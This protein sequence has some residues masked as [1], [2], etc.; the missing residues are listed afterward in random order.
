MSPQPDSAPPGRAASSHRDT[1]SAALPAREHGPRSARLGDFTLDARVLPITAL[2]LVV[3]AAGAGA[4]YCLLRL[5]GLITNL[6]FYQRVST[7]LVA[8]GA[9]HHNPALILLAPGG[10]RAGRSG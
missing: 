9:V 2:A 10:G 1:A 4:A 7:A 3:G 5:I 6:V 8:P